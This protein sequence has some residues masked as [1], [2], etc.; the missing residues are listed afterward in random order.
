[1]HVMTKITRENYRF[2]NIPT[3]E[4]SFKIV[5]FDAMLIG[6]QFGQFSARGYIWIQMDISLK[7]N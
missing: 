7:L 3:S 5:L 1:M 6:Q 2:K 4:N